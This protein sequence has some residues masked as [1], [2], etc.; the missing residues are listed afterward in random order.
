MSADCDVIAIVEEAF[1]LAIINANDPVVAIVSQGEQGAPGDARWERHQ[2]NTPGVYAPTI[3]G[4]QLQLE[5]D[6]TAG[7]I[8]VNLP[9]S[10]LML[11]LDLRV[12]R[13][14]ASSNR[15][16]VPAHAGQTIRGSASYDDLY[17]QWECLQINAVS[18]GWNIV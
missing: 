9:D 15:L 12:I 11:G 1:T 17:D 6:T 8:T 16:F 2:I 14:D 13:A 4:N 3:T 7:D 5:F 18:G 10:A